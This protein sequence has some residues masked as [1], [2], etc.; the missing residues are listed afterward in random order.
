MKQIMLPVTIHLNIRLPL[1][2]IQPEPAGS[3]ELPTAP[4]PEAH[5]CRNCHSCGGCGKCQHE[6]EQS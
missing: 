2:V 5:S 6:E 1:A 3:P 4:E